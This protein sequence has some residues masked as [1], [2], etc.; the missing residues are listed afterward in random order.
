MSNQ[1]FNQN[2]F[3]RL[4]SP[5]VQEN[6]NIEIPWYRL[7]IT[8]W[9]RTGGSGG[10]TSVVPTGVIMDWAGPEENIPNG[11]FL[12]NGLLVSRTAQANLFDAIGTSWGAGDGFSTFAL[13]NL[14]GRFRKGTDGAPG[15]V[16]GALAINL[17]TNQLPAHGHN[18]TD[19]GH[20]HAVTDPGHTHVVTD[21][22]H[23][24]IQQVVSDPTDGV[25]GSRGSSTANNTSIGTTDPA[26]TGITIANAT[27]GLTVD[28]HSTGITGT[29]LTGN[30]DAV[31]IE[32]LNA[33]VL[34][35]IKA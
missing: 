23:S 16:A 25:V 3:P 9:N 32:P 22:Q 14:I 11:W 34:P 19:P 2:G 35:I 24:H 29:Q 12:C 4:N 20:I 15:V 6:R 21:P 27:T 18:I 30:G 13:P 31:S 33:T 1:D 7:L 28:S 5:F 17:S 8:I 26:S 10:G